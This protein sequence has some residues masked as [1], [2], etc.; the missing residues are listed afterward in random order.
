MKKLAKKIK[1]LVDGKPRFTVRAQRIDVK[2][3][4]KWKL[5]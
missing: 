5:T 2:S 4:T 1:V 3:E